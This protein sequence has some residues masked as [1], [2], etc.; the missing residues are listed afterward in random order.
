MT[1]GMGGKKLNFSL[2]LPTVRVQIHLNTPPRVFKSRVR[3]SPASHFP[4]MLFS[5]NYQVSDVHLSFSPLVMHASQ[6]TEP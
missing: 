3:G 2:V 1:S 6:L 4:V 5:W